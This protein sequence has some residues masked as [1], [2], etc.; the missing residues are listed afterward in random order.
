MSRHHVHLTTDLNLA[1]QVGARRGQSAVFE[2][3]TRAMDADGYD[4]YQTANQVWLV[5]R[6]P[7]NYLQLLES[8][9]S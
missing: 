8:S 2:I 7:P 9:I 5:D 4:F 1:H 3:D 6:V